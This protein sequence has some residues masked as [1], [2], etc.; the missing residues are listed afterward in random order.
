MVSS[1]AYTQS[2]CVENKDTQAE[3]LKIPLTLKRSKCNNGKTNLNYDC[4]DLVIKNTWTT[5]LRHLTLKRSKCSNGKTNR[6]C[7]CSDLVIKNSLTTLLRVLLILKVHCR[8]N[9]INSKQI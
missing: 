3:K 2:C 1:I 4:N 7:D 5:L 6:N 9:E 8:D